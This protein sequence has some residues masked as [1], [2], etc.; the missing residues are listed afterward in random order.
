MLNALYLQF[1]NDFYTLGRGS[2]WVHGKQV[3][4]NILRKLPT[5]RRFTNGSK[6]SV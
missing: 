1:I 4:A 2:P 3:A 5:P 6:I